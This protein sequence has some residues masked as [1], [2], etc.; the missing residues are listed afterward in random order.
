MKNTVFVS[1]CLLLSAGFVTAAVRYPAEVGGL[2][3]GA[4]LA[5]F[6]AI[7]IV[8]LDA[9]NY[10]VREIQRKRNDVEGK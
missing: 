4:V 3:F 2:V 6:G 1:L 5:F 10:V 7:E 8:I 9:R